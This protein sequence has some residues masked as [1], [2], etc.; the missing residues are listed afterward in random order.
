M[1]L[2]PQEQREL[3]ELELKELEA[4]AAASPRT[5][6]IPP[7][8]AGIGGGGTPVVPGK[9]EAGLAIDLALEAG[10]PAVGQA[11]ASPT[12]PAGQSALGAFL[13]GAGNVLAQGRRVAMGEQEDFSKGQL[14]QAVATGAVPF[15]GPARNAERLMHPFLRGGLQVGKSAGLQGAVGF[16]G[17]A[18]KTGIDE[19]RLPG[20]GESI[21]SAGL[22]ALVGGA[23]TLVSQSGNRMVTRG[24]RVAENAETFGAA[25]ITPTAGMLL[26]EELGSIEQKIARNTPE[27]R[28]SNRIDATRGE[29]TDTL[30]NIAPNPQEGAAIFA[31][32][33]PLL[34]KISK[35]QDEIAKLSEEAVRAREKVSATFR[36]LR[37]QQ[38][39]QQGNVDKAV[40]KAAE[41]AS[42]EAFTANLDSVM[43]NAQDLAVAKATGGE[44]G[45]D[46]ATARTLFVEHVAKPLQGA[47]EEKSAQMYSLVDHEA[48]TFSAQPILD[49]AEELTRAASGKLPA[50]LQS[51][52]Q[53]LRDML[54]NDGLPVSLQDLRN[55]RAEL[56]KR[57]QMGQEL[58]SYEEKMIKEV[59]SEITRQ[60]DSQAVAALGEEG[61]AALKAANKFYSETRKL[62]DNPGVEVLFSPMPADE[63]VRKVVRGMQ[64]SG[65]NSDE[66]VGLQKL[67]DKI[68]E[69]RPELAQQ[70][71][72]Q[73]KD[74]LHQSILF[75]SAEL[76][77]VSGE[78]KVS[79]Q[80]LLGSL[81]PMSRVAGT[82]EALGFG[83]RDTV[84]EL[85]RLFDKYPDAP[86]MTTAQWDTLTASPAFRTTKGAKELRPA[87]E[88]LLATAAA[89]TQLTRAAILRNA[90]AVKKSQQVHDVAMA[91]LREANG[92]V[93][94]ARAKYDQLLQDPVA[95]ALNNPNLPASDY[96]AFARA[97]FDPKANAVT[98][99][100]LAD[101]VT[102]MRNGPR[103]VRETL[104][105]LQERY[106]A[107]KIAAYRSTPSPSKLL[108][109]TDAETVARFFNPANPG[110][111][112]NEL[113]RAQTILDPQQVSLLANFAKVAKAVERYEN[114]GQELLKPGS[115]DFPL[116]SW[117]RRVYDAV[118]SWYRDGRYVRMAE[119]MTDPA[120]FSRGQLRGGERRQAIGQGMATGAQGVGRATTERMDRN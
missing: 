92:D 103:P 8:A 28:V 12:S 65:I 115:H 13:S 37:E 98:N 53:N 35:S 5:N 6:S 95:V 63:Y 31:E 23:G 39:K 71:K 80:K 90:G 17:E 47:F 52:V 30:N 86:E 32:I 73:V 22:P 112:S 113:A 20:L 110:D 74:N 109:E 116:V 56:L 66:Y 91:N 76:D 57:V 100:E 79:G 89:D 104:T 99:A 45:V 97:F 68:G 41:V 38:A 108:N 96:N 106:I 111:A 82:M 81:E 1:P 24:R 55:T 77:P 48:R 44:L 59:A 42:D 33:E 101:V 16:A 117:P 4:K 105:R 107:D 94:A 50:K 83:S 26:P 118:T 84:V 88:P 11:I 25:D 21:A 87:L 62:F 49:K 54:G 114:F 120:A 64:S 69:S 60:I 34:G 3:D 14:A 61:G 18:I 70:V 2:T 27:G 51:S 72:Q 36:T 10:I 46:P 58:G 102:T 119:A 15:V 40:Q 43:R 85:K 67:A 9:G 93:A 7:Y 19:Q 29:M 78:M 75:D